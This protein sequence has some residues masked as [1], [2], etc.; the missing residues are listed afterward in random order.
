MGDVEFKSHGIP[1]LARVNLGGERSHRLS[2]G[3]C[4]APVKQSIG[5][6]VSLNW[7]GRGAFLRRDQ[8]EDHAETLDQC[9]GEVRERDR[10]VSHDT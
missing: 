6:S 5:L 9:A 2:E 7:H 1:A 8:G 10:D 4:G 3:G